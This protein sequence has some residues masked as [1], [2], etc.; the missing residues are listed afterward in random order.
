MKLVGY[1]VMR[2]LLTI[3]VPLIL[4][5]C[6]YDPHAHLYT[7]HEPKTEDVVGTYILDR[8][9]LPTDVG[10][11]RPN[12]EVELRSD[13]TFSAT[14]V[15][16]W[17]LETPDADFFASMISGNGTWKKEITGTLGPDLNHI[18]GIT[19]RTPDKQFHSAY[20]TGDKSPHGLMFT[21]GDPDEGYAVILKRKQ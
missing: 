2:N 9:H 18:W 11:A 7:T 1:F 8:F 17:S 19:L 13:G 3:L 21:L 10:N 15:P 6:Q 4:A 20:F 5:G 16:K 14:N 12:V